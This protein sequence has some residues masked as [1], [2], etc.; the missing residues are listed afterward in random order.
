MVMK[1]IIVIF[2]VFCIITNFKASA[3]ANNPIGITIM[4]GTE[5]VFF[6]G[7]EPIIKEDRTL[8][9]IRSVFEQMGARVEW[10]DEEK[11]VTVIDGENIVLITIGSNIMLKGG[12]EIAIDVPA[13]IQNNRTLL[14]LRAIA[15]ALDWHVFW[16]ESSKMVSLYKFDENNVHDIKLSEYI[17]KNHYMIE[18]FIHTEYGTVVYMNLSSPHGST[19]MLKF[20]DTNGDEHGFYNLVPLLTLNIHPE[21][22]NLTISDDRKILTYS[23]SFEER[24]VMNISERE[25]VL[26]EAGTYYFMANLETKQYELI[27]FEPVSE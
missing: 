3:L 23:V 13:E 18:E 12:N 15:E 17:D 8:V 20:V 26:H 1:K 11:S 24:A 16:G 27:S 6:E 2:F 7:Q 21:C 22:D 25:I 19:A 9:P 5:K 4:V 14:P 10:N